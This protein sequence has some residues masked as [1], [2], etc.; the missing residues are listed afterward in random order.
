[1]NG[2]VQITNDWGGGYCAVVVVTNNTSQAVTS[3]VVTLAVDGTVT[4]LWNANWTQTGNQLQVTSFSWNGNL[5]PGQANNS[6]G[7]CAD[8]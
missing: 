1:M 7:F 3:W 4:S 8:R 6:V 2:Q 5:Q